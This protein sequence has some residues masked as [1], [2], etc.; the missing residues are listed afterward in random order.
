MRIIS[1]SSGKAFALFARFYKYFAA[2]PIS[3]LS[4][5]RAQIFCVNICAT[6]SVLESRFHGTRRKFSGWNAA[7]IEASGGCRRVA[8][9]RLAQRSGKNS[10]A[11]YAASALPQG[12]PGNRGRRQGLAETVGRNE[13]R[14]L[15]ASE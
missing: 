9:R 1:R 4:V 2:F 6:I 11:A 14:V 13:E 7:S 12:M 5:S 3:R 15:R 8:F 10:G